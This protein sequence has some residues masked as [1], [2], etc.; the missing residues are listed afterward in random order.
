[1]PNLTRSLETFSGSGKNTFGWC[2][3]FNSLMMFYVVEPL[4]IILLLV[5]GSFNVTET[6]QKHM[7]S[8]E[9]K[10]AQN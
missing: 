8:S 9:L 6:N 2:D 3:D 4:H 10:N 7:D 1:M 5:N